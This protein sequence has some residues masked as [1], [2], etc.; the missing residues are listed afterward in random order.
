[1][2]HNRR[3]D[4]FKNSGSAVKLAA[5]LIGT[6]LIVWAAGFEIAVAILVLMTILVNAD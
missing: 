1:M 3:K 5:A 4:D 2:Q 6:V